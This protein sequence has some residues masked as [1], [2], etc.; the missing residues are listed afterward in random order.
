MKDKKLVYI[1]VIVLVLIGII[2]L[3]LSLSKMEKKKEIDYDKEYELQDLNDY[4]YVFVN[5]YND[6]QMYIEERK[7]E[8]VHI[9][10]TELNEDKFNGSRYLLLI[11]QINGCRENLK[12]SNTKYE[13]DSYKIYFNKSLSCGL[14]A[15]ERIMYQIKVGAS[16]TE[17]ISI[18]EK[19]ISEEKC[20]NDVLY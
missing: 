20:N 9:S 6:Y 3:A 19:I 1:F 16:E 8:G 14:C 11:A 2:C 18:Y 4:E 12:Y 10:G 5:K 13:D 15:P 17:K 7:N